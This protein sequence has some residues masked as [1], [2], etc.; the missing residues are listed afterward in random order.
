MEKYEKIVDALRCISG[1]METKDC[2]GCKYSRAE[3]ITDEH[4]EFA[5]ENGFVYI[6]GVCAA[7]SDA[8]DAIEEMAKKIKE[9]E[10]D[11][12]SHEL[13]DEKIIN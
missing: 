1:G 9:L 3:K 13:T 6:C 7:S 5:D 11:L 10:L 12:R 8:A 4:K 2:N